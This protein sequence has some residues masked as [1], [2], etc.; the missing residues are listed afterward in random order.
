MSQAC[1]VRERASVND[2][3][4]PLVTLISCI[5]C[6]R[7]MRLEKSDPGDDGKDLI[8]YRCEQCGRI[9]RVHLIRGAWPLAR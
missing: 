8:Q 1:M 7:A 2:D 3:R 9:E 4:S 5:V 6:N